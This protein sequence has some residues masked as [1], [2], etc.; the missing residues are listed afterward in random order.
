M[1]Y[2]LSLFKPEIRS[3]QSQIQNPQSTILTY[4]LPGTVSICLMYD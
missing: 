4:P 2:T 1:L 3:L